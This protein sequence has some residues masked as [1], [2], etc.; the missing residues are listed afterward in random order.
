MEIQNHQN[1]YLEQSIHSLYGVFYA[2]RHF[3]LGTYN[4]LIETGEANR[5]LLKFLPKDD[6]FDHHCFRTL[7]DQVLFQKFKGAFYC[8]TLPL[9]LKLHLLEDILKNVDLDGVS[10]FPP[11]TR[12]FQNFYHRKM[13]TRRNLEMSGYLHLSQYLKNNSITSKIPSYEINIR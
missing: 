9:V 4:P 13:I 10:T 2:Q 7:Q 11:W 12:L 6:F 3:P 5:L 1:N 8:S